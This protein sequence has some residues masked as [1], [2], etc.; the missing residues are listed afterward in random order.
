MIVRIDSA[1][2]PSLEDVDNFRAFKLIC[3]SPREACAGSFAKIGRLDGDH[4][5][6]DADWIRTNGRQDEEWVAGLGKM[7]DYAASAGWVD[8]G[9][10]IRVHIEDI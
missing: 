10:A 5:W 6:V 9:G 1:N 8:D 4:L 7:I 3:E 2:P